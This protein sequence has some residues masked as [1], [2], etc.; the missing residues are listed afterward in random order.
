MNAGKEKWNP[1]ADWVDQKIE[2][3]KIMISKEDLRRFNQRSDVKA[4]LQTAG[5]LSVFAVTGGIAW[6]A[7][8]H[9]HWILMGLALYL[10]GSFY[11]YF[12]SRQ[13]ELAHRTLFENKR[14]HAAVNALFAFLN[15]PLNPALYR[16]SH[17]QYHHRYTLYQNSDGEET[18]TYIELTPKFIAGIFLN[19]IHPVALLQNL[20]R[21]L[22]LKP[23]S[24]G[25]RGRAF[26]PDAW[27][28]FVVENASEKERR[29]IRRF[30][31]FQLV[32]QVIFVSACLLS[33]VWFP[34][35]LI[36]LAP[37]YGARWHQTYCTSHQHLAR[38]ANHPDFRG[39][40]NTVFL[41][42][43]S[44]LLY[45]HMEYHIEHHMFASIPS[46]HLKAFSNFIA[47]QLPAREPAF[48]HLL[49]MNRVCR[50]K[51][52]SWQY[53]LENFGFYKGL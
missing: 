38:E 8:S 27:E 30:A 41:D 3:D 21:L 9:G 51:Y 26:R 25:W 13:H 15:W 39:N 37:F 6:W 47:D 52:G 7:L 46:Y 1:H 12:A 2:W 34:I 29:D 42:P 49:Q 40:C 16:V 35:V 10:H 18:P 23:T 14:L 20:G 33:G 36:T 17:T 5:F 53:W 22:T 45:W 44:S 50:E 28:Q 32:S 48:K 31:V 11:G 24:R 19:M 43:L 4:V